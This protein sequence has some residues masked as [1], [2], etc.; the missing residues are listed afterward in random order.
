MDGPY[1]GIDIGSSSSKGVIVDPAGLVLHRARV[2]HTMSLPQ[3]GWAEHDA[4]GL[5]G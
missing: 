4:E 1:L 3:P 2:A 5:V